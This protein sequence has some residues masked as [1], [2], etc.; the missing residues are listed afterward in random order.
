L[1]I[2]TT[3]NGGAIWDRIPPAQLPAV[4]PQEGI[5][6]T[7]G[8]G[9]YAAIS[10]TIWF[11]TRRGRVW[12]SFNKG[13]SWEAQSTDSTIF[14]QAFSVSFKDA[15]NGL[16]VGEGRGFRT[17][18]GGN[19]WE[20]LSLPPSFIYYQI[21]YVP[22][23]NGVYYL[24]Y[25]GS[26]F[27][28][29]DIKHAFTLNN[30]DSWVLIDNPGIECFD[31][32]SATSAWGG[33]FIISP[34]QG[35]M[36]KWTGNLERDFFSVGKFEKI[37]PYTIITPQQLDTLKWNLELTN[38]GYQ[39]LTNMV[40]DFEVTKNGTSQ[41]F[42]STIDTI[43]FGETS[44]IPFNFLPTAVGKYTISA[45]ASNAQLGDDFYQGFEYF[46]IND[47][48]LAKDDGTQESQLGFGF[49]NPN[50]YGYYG[51]AFE[52][53]VPDTLTAITVY[54]SRFSN[55][56]GSIN[57]TVNAFDST[58]SPNIELYHSKKIKL[59]EYGITSSNNKLTYPLEI[60]LPLATGSYVFA[61]GQDTLQGVIGFDFDLDNVSD[62]GFWIVSP[63]A[64]GGYPWAHATNRETMM[65]RPHFKTQV[66]TTGTKDLTDITNQIRLFPNPFTD[67]TLLEFELKDH[68]LP[69]EIVVSDIL[70]RTLKSF[71]L[72]KPN[73]GVN[74]LPL[75]M[76]APAGLL[77]LT[78]K[79]GKGIKTIRLV[80][81]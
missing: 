21:A 69:V 57:L 59:S 27:Y 33:G 70:G 28:Y 66:A 73:A 47:S 65:I 1:R 37:S 45:S 46:E 55:F 53:N 29:T 23:T 81:Q 54:I 14:N 63:I 68:T 22:G 39:P 19:A 72:E 74:Q 58:G 62:D 50:W 20:E 52:L 34:S 13:V 17:Q 15:N 48:I 10:D 9:S 24:S 31:F 36:Y 8:I 60:P 30:G 75:T 5:W 76:D 40:L 49:G 71:R 3:S 61:A 32:L 18:D 11:A 6:I 7:Y 77:L 38:G 26:P 51:S 35:G 41:N 25:E 4:L 56:T 16:L 2:W 80:K 44:Q 43:G 64:G 79:Q 78:L 12:R 42:Q 67:Q